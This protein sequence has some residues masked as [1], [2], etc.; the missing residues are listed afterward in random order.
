M[1]RK[2]IITASSIFV[3]F[4][5]MTAVALQA[6]AYTTSI[7]NLGIECIRDYYNPGDVP[8]PGG[9][10]CRASCANPGSYCSDHSD[11]NQ[12]PAF[13][14]WRSTASAFLTTN[15]KAHSPDIASVSVWILCSDGQWYGQQANL[16]YSPNGTT[17]NSSSVQVS[18]PFGLSASRIETFQQIAK[19]GGS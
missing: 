15:Y 12:P 10:S 19:N 11:F 1:K 4:A 3:C 16:P 17:N 2:L 7:S 5:V 9:N 18:C 8:F 6:N 13:G 14:S